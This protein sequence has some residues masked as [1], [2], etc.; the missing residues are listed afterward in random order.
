MLSSLLFVIIEDRNRG[1]VGNEIGAIPSTQAPDYI[2]PVSEGVGCAF[3]G[4]PQA[5][6]GTVSTTYKGLKCQHWDAMYP[7]QHKYR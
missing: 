6:R 4:N 7:H 3:I 1:P 5:Y 2:Q